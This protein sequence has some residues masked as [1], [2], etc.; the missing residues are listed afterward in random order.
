M[1]RPFLWLLTGLVL[2]ETA[3]IKFGWS[4]VL[5]FALSLA[6]LMRFIRKAGRQSLF[7]LLLS[8]IIGGISFLV[9]GWKTPADRE[10][11]KGQA[12]NAV[13]GEI[14][15]VQEKNDGSCRFLLRK[16]I[17]EDVGKSTGEKSRGRVSGQVEVIL[18]A[19]EEAGWLPGQ[20]VRVQGKWKLLTGPTNP[21]EFDSRIYQR[22]RGV[23]WQMYGEQVEEIGGKRTE[24]TAA[25]CLLRKRLG[26]VFEKVVSG[27]EAALLKAISLGD[28][29]DLSEEQK[30]LYEENGASHLL[31]VS[32]LHVSVIGGRWYRMLR[33]RKCG[34]TISCL[35][36]GVLLLFYGCMTGFG[37]SCARAVLMYLCYL[38]AEYCGMQYDMISAMSLAGI[39]LL[40]EHPWRCLEGGFQVSFAAVFLIGS[41]LP[42]MQELR[43]NKKRHREENGIGHPWKKKM[44]DKLFA[45][46]V[47]TGGLAPLLMHI[48]YQW[49]P[50]SI[51]FNLLLL[52][53]MEP[54]MGSAMLAA[55]GGLF[56]FPLGRICILPAQGILRIFRILFTL[57]SRLPGTPL[58]TGC[59]SWGAVVVLYGL[60]AAAVWIWYRKKWRYA[61]W[62]IGL[63]VGVALSQT[64]HL[65][66]ITMLDVGQGDGILVQFPNEKTMMIDGGSSS[67]S[68]TGKYILLPALKYYGIAGLDYL[69]VTH[70]DE[71]HISGIRELL[72]AGYPVRELLLP[73][74]ED[75]DSEWIELKKMASQT[76]TK[77]HVVA[78]GDRI[79]EG[80][81]SI[82]CLHPIYGEE[83]KEDRNASSIVLLVQLGKFDALF[84]GD[85]P[86]SEEDT[87]CQWVEEHPGTIAGELE[88]LKVAHHGSKY[89]TGE[90]FLYCLPPKLA[91]IS[92]GNS[93]GHPHPEL[94]DR[95]ESCGADIMQTKTGGA[96]NVST[97]GTH[98]ESGYYRKDKEIQ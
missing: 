11:E 48:Y 52:P 7:L 24:W 63:L 12:G 51:L 86:E 65:L 9:T 23:R 27:E 29:T 87:L 91:L 94:I 71:D 67:R 82:R 53:A 26:A 88:V 74:V 42:K 37:S 89:S 81:V 47:I 90:S 5:V 40:L 56:S 68:K 76:G 64:N 38:L 93:Y 6:F 25:A 22:A 41:I 19:G 14:S 15:F 84:T 97:D 31:A 92:A 60:E 21:G 4:G 43:K 59:P 66:R 3:A 18:S 95:L 39:S 17:C 69:V 80:N 61:L 57:G 32:G 77:V 50:L 44:S 45:S 35:S 28:K 85:L 55:L 79:R 1:K 72:R 20:K 10:I 36:G 70:V 54:L 96:I 49:T 2:G 30:S 98:W 78:Q 75:P 62:G 16:V 46:V 83:K 33:R 34:Y 58:V 8:V 13:T 73:F